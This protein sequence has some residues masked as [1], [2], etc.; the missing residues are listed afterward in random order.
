[1]LRFIAERSKWVADEIWHP[2]QKGRFEN[3]QYVLEVPYSD[4]RELV[5]DVL[6]HGSEVEVLSPPALR[7]EV[8]DKLGQARALYKTG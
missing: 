2:R 1:M 6:K 4:A 5:M 7:T 8:R 3:G